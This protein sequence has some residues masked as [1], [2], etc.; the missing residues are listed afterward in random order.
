MMA[1]ED[2]DI[3]NCQL[4]HLCQHLTI[5]KNPAMYSYILHELSPGDW[6]KIEPCPICRRL[7]TIP[8]GGFTDLP[9][10]TFIE[11]MIR[12]RNL[13]TPTLLK[14][15]PCE[16]CIKQTKS[17]STKEVYAVDIYCVDYRQKFCEYCSK[18]HRK[19]ILT[20][21]HRLIYPSEQDPTDHD[22]ISVLASCDCALHRQTMLDIHCFSC[23][24]VVCNM[25]FIETHRNHDGK[26]VSTIA[27]QFRKDI[28][29]CIE[30]VNDWISRAQTKRTE[31]E[32]DKDFLDENTQ[33]VASEI[34]QRKAELERILNTSVCLLKDQL[35]GFKN[36]SLKEIEAEIEEN[37]LC[38]IS[39]TSYSQ[40][41]Q[42]I[43]TR[44]SPSD[45]CG[46]SSHL[47]AR[48]VE[49]E[50]ETQPLLK[51]RNSH[52]NITLEKTD[53]NEFIRPD[54]VG[55]LG[56]IAGIHVSSRV[57]VQSPSLQK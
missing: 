44:G 23:N 6:T 18:G 56:H 8:K 31:L 9:S 14:L 33:D 39:L 38:L 43:L 21:D 40:Y 3:T 11:R 16:A 51:P 4:L 46:A 26:H 20:R 30:K 19:F 54:G 49:L 35:D 37:D 45:V 24:E 15:T 36:E 47:S 28:E 57:L 7:F 48:A 17:D 27:D 42:S 32:R 41:C 10:N 2:R 53:L 25:C 12:V 52:I 22:L 34:L 5:S 50:N 13:L 55:F 29:S 1:S